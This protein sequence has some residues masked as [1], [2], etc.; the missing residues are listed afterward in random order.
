M[1]LKCRGRQSCQFTDTYLAVTIDKAEADH[2][3][4]TVL[5]MVALGV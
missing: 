2:R 5:I 4:V 1:L 3:S